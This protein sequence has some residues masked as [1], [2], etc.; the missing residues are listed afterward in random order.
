MTEVCPDQAQWQA[1]LEGNGYPNR[2]EFA[3]HLEGCRNCQDLLDRRAAADR[4]LMKM[5]QVVYLPKEEPALTR[6]LNRLKGRTPQ[7]GIGAD[8]DVP[9]ALEGYEI[10]EEI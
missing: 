9:S 2:E 4:E 3:V 8:G 6:A 7:A 5:A 1:W 10:M